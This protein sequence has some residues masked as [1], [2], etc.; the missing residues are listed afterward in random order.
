MKDLSGIV[1]AQHYA[2]KDDKRPHIHCYVPCNEPMTK[3]QFM[4]Y[5]RSLQGF[6]IITGNQDF[7]L[8]PPKGEFK[9]WYQYVYGGPVGAWPFREV[10][11]YAFKQIRP[12]D[13]VYPVKENTIVTSPVEYE[14]SPLEL[15]K[16]D[17][18]G[19]YKYCNERF[20]DPTHEDICKAWLRFCHSKYSLNPVKS[21]ENQ[22]RHVFWRFKKDKAKTHDTKRELEQLETQWALQ[23]R[24]KIF[25][26]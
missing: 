23:L 14:K 15:C 19:F 8:H 7:G 1:I 2:D 21:T 22:I 12:W 17:P 3:F 25:G 9:D 18:D 16:K 20:T 26:Y 13:Y 24:E 11:E 4:K 10:V 6:P 5:I